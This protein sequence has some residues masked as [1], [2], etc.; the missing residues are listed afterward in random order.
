[1][2]SP[3]RIAIVLAGCMCLPLPAV[4]TIATKVAE[5][6]IEIAVEKAARTSGKKFSGTVAKKVATDEVKRLV[7]THGEDVLKVVEDSGLELLEA[8][9]K[10]GEDLISIA[11]RASPQARR[12]LALSVEEMLPLAKRVGVEA[13]E[14]E[15]KV[16]GQ[17]AHALEIFGDSAGKG[18]AKSIPTEDLPRLIKYGEKSDSAAT[19]EL[20]L[21]TYKAEGPKLF[22]RIPPNLVL[23]GGLSA[24][25]LLGTH[26][27]FA[28]ERAKADVL[29][30][31]PEIARDVMNRST[32][33]WG[34]IV[35]VVVLLLLWRFGLMPWHGRES[36]KSH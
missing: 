9:P 2:N 22:E 30:D 3:L 1:M 11:M 35:L 24:S 5:Q 7:Q 21:K 29:R 32:A 12:A 26:E 23:A 17:A 15:A 36:K 16:P 20:L 18:L 34:G 14:L 19:K 13:L 25:M 8:V 6:A 4:A 27:A 31:N 28:T 33:V 10:H